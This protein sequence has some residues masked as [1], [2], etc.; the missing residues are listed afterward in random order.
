MRV[1]PIGVKVTG[2][3]GGKDLMGIGTG[4]GPQQ[5]KIR[6]GQGNRRPSEIRIILGIAEILY[7]QIAG[8]L[9]K[10]EG[11]V[12]DRVGDTKTATETKREIVKKSD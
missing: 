5:Q 11:T 12:K 10:T 8:T 1:G 3:Y 7:G 2:G 9:M 4:P 6:P